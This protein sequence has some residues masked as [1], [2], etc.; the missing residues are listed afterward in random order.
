MAYMSE[1]EKTAVEGTPVNAGTYEVVIN[2]TEG[3]NYNKVENM[4][5]G[6][7]TIT[8]K[9]QETPNV[10]IDKETVKMT[11]EAPK[12][13]LG[14]EPAEEGEVT[15]TSSNTNVITISEAGEITLVGAG[16]A[17]IKV[18]YGETENYSLTTSEE[19]TITVVRDDLEETDFTFTPETT[20]YSGAEQGV[21]VTANEGIDKIGGRYKSS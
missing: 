3:I 4:V 5:I 15:Y 9:A 16:T 11:E 14:N 7:Y 6:T 2:V 17:E 19:K 18:T 8:K 1:E 21:T 10:T 12:I 13:T 20:T